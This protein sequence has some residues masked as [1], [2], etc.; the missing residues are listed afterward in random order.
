MMMIYDD[1]VFDVESS[2]EDDD[3]AGTA[4]CQMTSNIWLSNTDQ[5]VHAESL[6]LALT[7]Y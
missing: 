4:T 2:E 1:D 7:L 3:T 5:K 6:L